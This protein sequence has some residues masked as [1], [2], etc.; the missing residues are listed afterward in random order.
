MKNNR[1]VRLFCRTVRQTICRSGPALALVLLAAAPALA[2]QTHGDP[3]GLVVHQISHI[4]FL[5]SMGLL[6][7]WIRTRKLIE[8][9]AWRYI[10]YAALLFMIWTLDAFATH[11]IDEHYDWIRVT[12]AGPWHINIEAKNLSTAVFYYLVKM[13]HLWSVPA[14]MFMY[15]GLRRLNRASRDE[16]LR[17]GTSDRTA[18]A[19]PLY[20]PDQT[21]HT[22]FPRRPEK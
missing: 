4:F 5:F 18:P 6:I 19:D 3:E 11:L 8:K 1:V 21:I 9:A 22:V 13:D 15:L 16:N 14:M 2:T 20:L 7:Y 17:S 12:R 10:Q